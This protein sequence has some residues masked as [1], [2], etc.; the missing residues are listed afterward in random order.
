MHNNKTHMFGTTVALE[1]EFSYGNVI[2]Q[3]DNYKEYFL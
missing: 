1:G 2:G 3:D